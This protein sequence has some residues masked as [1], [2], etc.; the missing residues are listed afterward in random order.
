MHVT[1][2]G[3]SS[4]LGLEGIHSS[5]GALSR[6]GL[7]LRRLIQLECEAECLAHLPESR[8][9]GDVFHSR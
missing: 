2:C 8:K 4:W 3:L 1:L 7:A 5:S 6:A 9:Y